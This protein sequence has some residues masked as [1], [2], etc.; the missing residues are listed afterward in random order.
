MTLASPNIPVDDIQAHIL[1]MRA[2]HKLQ[3]DVQPGGIPYDTQSGV[4]QPSKSTL[5]FL[6]NAMHRR[7]NFLFRPQ[8]IPPLDVLMVWHTYMLSPTAYYEDSLKAL[9][10]LA[11]L[12]GMPWALV[13]SCIDDK[14]WT[15][16]HNSV[17]IMHWEKL[18]SLPFNR[19]A[20]TEAPAAAKLP[21]T[22]VDLLKAVLRQS[23][24]LDNMLAEVAKFESAGNVQWITHA[25]REYDKYMRLPE[26]DYVPPL[27]VDIVW[28]THQ[29]SGMKYR[30]ESLKIFGQFIGHDDSHSPTVIRRGRL[31]TTS[32]LKAETTCTKTAEVTHGA[33]LDSDARC[34]CG[35]CLGPPPTRPRPRPPVC[36][37]PPSGCLRGPRPPSPEPRPTR[38]KY[39]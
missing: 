20:T 9:P 6:D 19:E 33:T 24:S 39:E 18:T 3:H 14:T 5:K 22:S 35:D 26:G 1:L 37:G 21:Q 30:D 10:A 38:D 4:P 28:H 31:L 16:K 32:A 34:L 23:L 36:P 27:D 25:I 11:S 13:V 17:Q 2:I 12:G 7:P 29:H 15:F 8:E